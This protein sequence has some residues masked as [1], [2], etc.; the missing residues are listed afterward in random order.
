MSQKAMQDHQNELDMKRMLK[1]R[2][3]KSMEA[4]LQAHHNDL[5]MKRQLAESRF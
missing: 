1:E 3:E 5:E 4:L 2:R